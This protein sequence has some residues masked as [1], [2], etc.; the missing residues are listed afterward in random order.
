MRD[1]TTHMDFF[2]AL[3]DW[4]DASAVKVGCYRGPETGH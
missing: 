3:T 1:K 4:I 2:C